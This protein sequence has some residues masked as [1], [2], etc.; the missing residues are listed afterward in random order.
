MLL[1]ARVLIEENKETRCKKMKG[2][3]EL[4]MWDKG[5]AREKCMVPVRLI[6]AIVEDKDGTFVETGRDEK[7]EGT[8]IF[9]AD[10]YEEVKQKIINCEV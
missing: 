4:T 3:L 10:S 9:A 2:F 7:G 8:G 5:K 6:T 1:P